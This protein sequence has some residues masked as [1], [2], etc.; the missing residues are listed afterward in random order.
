MDDAFVVSCVEGVNDVSGQIQKF[1]YLEPVV[2]DPVLEGPPFKQLHDD[3]R[4]TFMFTKIMDR[5]DVW[6]IQRRQRTRVRARSGRD[7]RRRRR[8]AAAAP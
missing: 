7:D 5:A 8:T 6:V 3:E 2:V 1:V 4:L